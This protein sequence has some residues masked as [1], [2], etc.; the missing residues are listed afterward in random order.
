MLELFLEL[1]NL[2]RLP[3]TGWLLRGIPNPEPIA[4]HSYRVAMITLFLADELKSRGV[5]IDVEKALKIALLHDVGEARITD[6]PLPAQRYFDK[7][8]G[9]VIALEEMLS[10]TGRGDE[11]LGLFREYEEE[12]SLE[13]RLVKFADR[14]EMLIQAFEYEK[15]GFRNLDE[16]WGVVEKLRESEF[17]DPF[18]ELVEGLVEQRT[19]FKK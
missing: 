9:E 4:A 2:K 8:K 18:R 19:T 14:L 10:V 5:E 3:R 13:G 12:L 7:V 11:Y 16:F 1:G 6:V 17:Y 15:A